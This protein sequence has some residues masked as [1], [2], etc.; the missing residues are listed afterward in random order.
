M[1]NLAAIAAQL[2]P[3][4]RELLMQELIRAG[5]ALP[6][7]SATAEPIAVVGIGCRLPGNV[8]GPESFWRLLVNGEDG[9]TEVPADRWDVDAFY[10]PDPSAPGRMTTR[11]GGFIP[12]A[13]GFDADFFGIAPREA[14]AMDPQ[15]RLLLEV[16]WEALEH[17]GI[18]PDSLAGTR[19][20]VMV[21]LSTWDYAIVNVERRADIDAYLSTGIPHNTAVGRLSYLL[22]LRGPS[23]AVDTACSSSLVA[24]HLAC[25][26]LRL[27]ES[28]LVL[29][30]GAQVN[31]SPFTS[32]ALSKWSAL[33]PEGR[34]KTFDARADGFVRGE[35]CGVVVLKRLT[36]AQRDGDRVLAVVRGSAVNQDGRSNGIT[37]PNALAQR[38]VITDALRAADVAADT[39]NYIE[40]HGTGTILGDPIE[41]EALSAT[42]GTGQ[43]PCALGAV[44]TNLGHL[45]AAAG[46]AGL[47]KAVLAV[48]RGQ[49]PS[50]L[51]FTRLN[52]A[53][54]ASPTRFF[55]P[56]ESAP[57]PTVTGPRRA[58]VSSFG[59]AGTNAHVVLEQAPDD[60]GPV[61]REPDP[62]VSTLVVSGKSV[63][64]IASTAAVLAEWMADE[65]AAV[66]LTDVAYTLNHH[67]A[68]HAKFATVCARD[69]A[70]AI[71]GLEALAAGRPA[72]GVV[73]PHEGRCGS[74]TVFVY[75]GQG[76]QWTGMGRQLLADELAFAAAVAE[77]EPVFVEQVGFSVQQ[78][79]AG[80]EPVS[81]DARVQPV[82]MGLQ[83]ALTELWRSYGIT[84]NAVIGHSM[85][86]V[87]AAVVAGALSVAEGLRVIAI[88]SRLMSRLAGQGAVALLELDA[89]ATV[90]LLADYPEVSVA[91]YISPSQ[92]VVAG[93]P[94]PVDGVIAAVTGQDRFARRVNMEVASHTALMDP[95]LPELRS[96]LADLAPQSPKIPFISTVADTTTPLLDADYWVANVRQPVRLSQ[97]VSTAAKNHTTFIEISPHPTL[98]HAITET[99]EPIRATEPA[100]VI[101]AMKK[102][103]DQTLFFHTQLAAVGMT[104]PD[105]GSGRRLADIPTTPWQHSTFYVA[106]RSTKWGRHDGHPLLGAHTEM[107][108]GH[109]HV[110]QADI[111]TD[112]GPWLLDY[113]VHGQAIMPAAGYVEIMLAAAT[114]AL[115]MP[116]HGVSVNDLKIEQLLTLD[117]HTQ[118]TTQLMRSDD[119]FRAEVHSRS[120]NGNWCRHAVAH[121]DLRSDN[122]VPERR[123]PPLESIGAAVSPADFYAA[124]RETGRHYGPAFTAVTRIVRLPG[125]LSE[126]DIA[127]PDDAPRHSEFRMHPVMLDA[128]LQSL[129]AVMPDN[130]ATE[131]VKSTYLPMS[132]EAIRVFGD[133][134]RHAHCRGEL[135]SLDE[136]GLG[137]IGRV[138]L[139]DDAGKVTAEI[140]GVY[141][142]R[143]DRWTIPLPLGQKVFDTEWAESPITVQ[144][145]PTTS[146]AE[147]GSWLVLHDDDAGAMA[148]EFTAQWGSTTRRVITA[149]LTD[150]SAIVA[151]FA[152]AGA[153]PDRP[154]T[155]IVIFVGGD[156]VDGTNPDAALDAARNSIWSI[157]AAVRAVVG[158][159][160]G[161]SPRMWFVTRRGLVVNDGEPGNPAIGALRGLVRV[162]AFEH[163]ELRATLVDLDRD[164]DPVA[165]IQEELESSDRDDVVAWREGRRFAERLSRATLPT[166][167]RDPVVRRGG[168]YIVTGGLGGLGMVIARWLVDRGAARVVLNGR[169]EPS[170]Q[171]REVLAELRNRAE[172]DI[173]RGDIASDAV[174]ERLVTAAEAGGLQLRGVVHAAAVIDDSLVAMMPRE[175]LDRVWSPKAA[176]A[177]RLHQATVAHEL[178]WWLAFSSTSSLL[179]SPGQTAYASANAWVDALVSW[180]RASGL[181]ATS[182]NWGP[183]S[184]VGVA[185]SLTNSAVDPITPSEGTEALESLLATDRAHTGV[186]RLRT[187]RALAAFPEIRRLGYFTQMVDELEMAGD[188]DDWAG[189]EGLRDLDPADAERIVTDRLRSRVAAVMGHANQS[190]L[191]PATPLLELGMDSL[192]AVRIR[193]AASADFGVEPPVP[194]LLQGASL[195]DVTADLIQQLGLAKEASTERTDAVRDQAHR[196]AAARQSGMRRKRGQRV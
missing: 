56:T 57:W 137:K 161:R 19:T 86:E 45:E 185:R 62:A 151:A 46:V 164:L 102:G 188:G 114:E 98:T 5:T 106:D 132:F 73:G 75:S 71:A 167:D 124:L 34:C 147:P 142:Q 37:A 179:G 133:V 21:G 105:T 131:S 181:P 103:K 67:R 83:L 156:A 1:T 182:I 104:S 150:E 53:I 116:V 148:D 78:V 140:T 145:A 125:G 152:E 16:A 94:A 193:H 135:V 186:A 162:L 70:Q 118:I 85:G 170:D 35:G 14:T 30:G 136:G 76:S 126:T 10:D 20:G 65:G 54:D 184:E 47:I 51:H 8:A 29:A 101:S 109:H 41:F 88:R 123:V 134:G 44:K 7:G 87:T 66:G 58:G 31:L 63:E 100:V 26:S 60:P 6:A 117:G 187:D 24:L 108:S 90:A 127:I 166:R 128:A 180:R 36:D 64:R 2:S 160:H 43:V 49:I 195:N 107:P 113:K 111:G 9:I 129:A 144:T 3:K 18:P 23:V 173:V 74:G 143:V 89:E 68:R 178:D 155:G 28:D 61:A 139:T 141:M 121:I 158:G 174:A 146:A 39:V 38:D 96:A 130:A 42:Y 32:I 169:S 159:W 77:L 138:T 99:L 59:F 25:Q 171:Q 168:S 93:P 33:S 115:G 165:R 119:Q 177:L 92:T 154:P 176:G 4:A 15:H 52:P 91:G 72:E 183:W 84:P 27:R 189:V 194:L 12:D 55:F 97:A 80:G 81:G 110:W 196:R 17:A 40:A 120:P 175:S 172:I 192:M 79:L 22:G 11:W 122:V 157:S 149:S 95:I 50:N 190:A 82:I 13:G 69:R 112:V 191:D 163:P 153:D 48:Q